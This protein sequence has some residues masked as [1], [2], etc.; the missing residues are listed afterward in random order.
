M[1]AKGGHSWSRGCDRTVTGE[2]RAV[3]F[4]TN[5]PP[6]HI[7]GYVKRLEGVNNWLY[8]STKAYITNETRNYMHDLGLHNYFI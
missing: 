1:T 3:Q 7:T 6:T 5:H 2:H 4:K 8:K